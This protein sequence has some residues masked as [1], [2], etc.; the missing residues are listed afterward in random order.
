MACRFL[1]VAIGI[2]LLAGARADAAVAFADNALAVNPIR[3]VVTMLQLMQKKITAEGKAEKELYDKFMCWCQTGGSDL[4]ASIDA[5]GIKIPQ[6]ESAIGEKEAQQAQLKSDLEAHKSDRAAALEAAAKAKVIRKKEHA[7]FLKESTDLK[8]NIDALTKAIAAL[9]KGMAGAFLQTS[10]AAVL[11][12]LTVSLDRLSDVDRDALT[13][14]LSDG[15]AGGDGYAPQSGEIVGILK[16]LAETMGKT[17]ADVVKA[18]EEAA[19]SFEAMVAAKTKQAETLTAAIESKTVL[20]GEVGV[21]LVNMKEDLDDTQAAL[22]EDKKFLADLDKN[23]AAKKADWDERSKTR[24][25]ELVAIAD[26][27]KILNDDDALELFK[28]T[29]PSPSLLQMRGK[30][31]EVR[32]RAAQLLNTVRTTSKSRDPRVEFIAMKLK[33]RGV[34]FEKVIKMIDDMVTLLGKEQVDDDAKKEYCTSEID[35]AEDEIKELERAVD[36]L[37]KAIEDRKELIAT[38]T[39]EIAALEKG[40]KELDKA[41]AEATEQRK[42]EH[43]D[44]VEALAANNAAKDIIGIAKN[45]L[46]KFYNPK[47]YVAPPKKELSEE[48]RITVN[49]GGEVLAQIS[50]HAVKDAPPPPPETYGAYAKKSQESGGVIAMMDMLAADLD[51]EIQESTVGEKNAQAEYEDFMADSSAKRADDTKAIADKEGAKAGAEAEAQKMSEEKKSTMM[52][53]MAKGEYL[54]DLHADCDWLVANYDIRKEARAGEVDA[55]KKA[56]AV[57]A[58][59]DFSLAQTAARLLRGSRV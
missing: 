10:A 44:F 12:R 19:A 2:A 21:D 17:L 32:R 52:S 40:I 38:A 51:K 20:L 22:L 11:R 56:K 14:F 23:C 7:D 41:V 47:L 33:A 24:A 3:R 28:K 43:A 58:G 6:V 53:A 59:A 25:E 36:G 48:E 5:A 34:S 50:A 15:A 30:N 9:E 35:K 37:E 31:A 42:D 55:L 39:E 8:T 46:N 18:E 54:K 27:I 4:Q 1:S 16:Q 29:L 13:S 26:T 45:R 49:M 57:L